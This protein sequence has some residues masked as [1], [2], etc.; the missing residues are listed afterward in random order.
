MSKRYSICYSD[1][2]MDDLRNIYIYIAYDL[3]SRDNAE[4]QVNRIRT[5]IKNL[6]RFPKT[7]PLMPYEPWKSIG[8]YRLNVDNYAVLYL[9][10][11]DHMR[12]EIVRIPYGAM[13]IDRLLEEDT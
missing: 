9:V 3:Q 7:N 6:D 5:A 8:M 4:G 11:D 1:E 12:V 10:N 2:A 13:D